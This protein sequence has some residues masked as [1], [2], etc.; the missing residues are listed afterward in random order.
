MASSFNLVSR[1]AQ[2]ALTEFSLEYDQALALG[3]VEPWAVP[4]GKYR[5]SKAIQTIYPL[6]ISAAG[7]V[8]RD[9]E[10]KFRTILSRSLSMKTKQWVD[11]VEEDSRVVEA[12]DFPGWDN[13]PA[14]IAQEGQRQPNKLVAGMLESNPLLD[15]YREKHEGGDTPSTI[16]L[17]ADNHPVNIYDPSMGTFD[18]DIS[19]VAINTA[20]VEETI[21]RFLTRQ[22]ANGENLGLALTTF[23]IPAGMAM[24]FRTLLSSDTLIEAVRNLAGSEVVAAALRQNLNKGIAEYIVGREFKVANVFYALDKNSMAKPWIV[25]DGGA[26]VEIRF[27]KT[28]DYWKRTGKLAVKYVLDMGVAAALPHAIERHTVTG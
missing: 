2:Q 11:G 15:L 22:G 27:D 23:L 13:E 14:R 20:M 16:R 24:T 7:Y 17:F 12:P 3:A 5:V 19:D 28:S 9:G 10:D 1:D 18:N 4:L 6:S 21:I 25:Q 26:P 8:E